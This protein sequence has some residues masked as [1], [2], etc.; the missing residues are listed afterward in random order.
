[1]SP[2]GEQVGLLEAENGAYGDAV[3]LR[4]TARVEREADSSVGDAVLPDGVLEY[5][6]DGVVLQDGVAVDLLREVFLDHLHGVDL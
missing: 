5:E 3:G 1:M 6:R 4:E 2:E